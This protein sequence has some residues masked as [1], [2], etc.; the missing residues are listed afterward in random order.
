[1]ELQSLS[2]CG[3]HFRHGTPPIVRM[4][5]KR[6]RDLRAHLC[7]ACEGRSPFSS[8]WAEYALRPLLAF[9]FRT[10]A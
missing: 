5:P 7:D 8:L 9:L 3:I 6:I 2:I 1:M 4:F 10:I